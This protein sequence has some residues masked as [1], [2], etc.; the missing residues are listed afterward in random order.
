MKITFRKSVFA[1]SRFLTKMMWDPSVQIATWQEFRQ[2]N[3]QNNPKKKGFEAH[4]E[5]SVILILGSK[6]FK[7]ITEKEFE[8]NPINFNFQ[9]NKNYKY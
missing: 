2:K 5:K 8:N 3:G 1:F 4:K 6:T 9:N 7:K